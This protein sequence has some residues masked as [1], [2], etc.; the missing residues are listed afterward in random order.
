MEKFFHT[1]K[2]LTDKE[3][4]DIARRAVVEDLLETTDRTFAFVKD[5][6][7]LIALH[8]GAEVVSVGEPAKRPGTRGALESMTSYCVTI[9]PTAST[10]SDGGVFADYDPSITIN[11]WFSGSETTFE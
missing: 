7:E 2:V 8:C 10:P 3:L 9:K 5:L 6:G 4:L 11:R 1:N